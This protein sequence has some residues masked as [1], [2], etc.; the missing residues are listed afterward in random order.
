M[1]SL[2]IERDMLIEYATPRKRANFICY[3]NLIEKT[4]NLNAFRS[5]EEI[6]EELGDNISYR[7]RELFKTQISCRRALWLNRKGVVVVK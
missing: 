3:Q 2:F 4:E 5:D 6:E 1:I 7:S